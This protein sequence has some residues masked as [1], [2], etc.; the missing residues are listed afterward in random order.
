M[1]D[2]QDGAAGSRRRDQLVG[3]FER[4]SDRLLDQAGDSG[5]EQH[6]TDRRVID[7]RSCNA[8][9]IYSADEFAR[10]GH[11]LASELRGVLAGA[12]EVR[13]DNRH[14][15]RFGQLVVNAGVM[16]AKAADA[17]DGGSEHQ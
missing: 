16:P 14:E 10:V 3:F 11:G 2:L 5:F 12:I 15:I 8:D 4:R 17:D 6:G 9:R 7:G 13:V 1:A